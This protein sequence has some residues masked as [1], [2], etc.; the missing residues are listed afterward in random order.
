VNK[1]VLPVLVE[2]R[3]NNAWQRL[4]GRQFAERQQGAMNLHGAQQHHVGWL[5]RRAGGGSRVVGR[6]RR[7]SGGPGFCG[8]GRFGPLVQECGFVK[9]LLG[10]FLAEERLNRDPG[11][12]AS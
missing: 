12:E 11:I 1:Q 7:S 10:E 5:G 6:H 4:V 9:S 8:G 2:G 3:K